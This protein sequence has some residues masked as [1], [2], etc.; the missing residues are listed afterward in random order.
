MVHPQARPRTVIEHTGLRHTL[1][2]MED[3]NGCRESPLIGS[4]PVL[5]S[6]FVQT[7]FWRA[8]AY[9]SWALVS[10]LT[11]RMFDSVALFGLISAA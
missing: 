4:T 2:T 5:G 8:V 9:L 11:I 6:L 10:L 1:T 7:V 3:N